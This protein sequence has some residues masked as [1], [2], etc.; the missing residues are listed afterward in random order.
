MLEQLGFQDFRLKSFQNSVFEKQT[1]NKCNSQKVVKSIPLY[2]I[3]LI[4]FFYRWQQL[5]SFLRQPR[6]RG[7]WSSATLVDWRCLDGIGTR[8]PGKIVFIFFFSF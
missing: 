3:L 1:K 2:F 6:Q 5:A 8:I 7:T 4:D